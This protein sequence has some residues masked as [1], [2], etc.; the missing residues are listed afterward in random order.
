MEIET[1]IFAGASLIISILCF[2]Y[3][4]FKVISDLKKDL[5]E[6]SEKIEA[7]VVSNGN[8]V[9]ILETKMELFWKNIEGIVLDTLKHPNTVR[10][11]E[12]IEKF[13]DRTIN[14]EELDE[15]KGILEPVI[16]EN[17]K[18]A[19]AY[20]AGLVVARIDS[21]LLDVKTIEELTK[22]P[23]RTPLKFLEE[24]RKHWKPI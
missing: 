17:S 6:G 13:G 5:Q 20:A 4:H 14:I 19:E 23:V 10:R 24:F 9:S 11:D 1:L 7:I 16:K 2:S 3:Q 8:R 15:L 18:S 12:L 22:K 21:I